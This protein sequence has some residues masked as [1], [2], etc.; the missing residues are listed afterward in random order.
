MVYDQDAIDKEAEEM[1]SK[2]ISLFKREA[3]TELR[4]TSL[5][6]QT[7]RSH[8]KLLETPLNELN[9]QLMIL[10]K[11]TTEYSEVEDMIGYYT[12]QLSVI[13]NEIALSDTESSLFEAGSRALNT[14]QMNN[15]ST[16]SVGAVDPNSLYINNMAS[17][18]NLLNA[19]SLISGSINNRP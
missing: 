18:A 3:S 7:L 12:Y 8:A 19:R 10:E 14:T 6:V 2:L 13:N 11:G 17:T 16:A 4:K 15:S 9:T 5:K 1:L